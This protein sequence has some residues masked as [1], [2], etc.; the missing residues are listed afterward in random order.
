MVAMSWQNIHRVSMPA[1]TNILIVIAIVIE[2]HYNQLKSVFCQMAYVTLPTRS[3]S[4]S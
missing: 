2:Y 4:K 3:L 1:G